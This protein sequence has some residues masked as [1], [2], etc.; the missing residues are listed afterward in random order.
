[1]RSIVLYLA[2]T[3]LEL[4]LV[5]NL[6]AQTISI[7]MIDIYSIN[8]DN[9]IIMLSY[10]FGSPVDGYDAAATS[11]T[12]LSQGYILSTGFI[13]NSTVLPNASTDLN[14]SID[15]DLILNALDTSTNLFD[16]QS[17]GFGLMPAGDSLELSFVFASEEFLNISPQNDMMGIFISGPNPNGGNYMHENISFIPGTNLPIT[18]YNLINPPYNSLIE[19]TGD[20]TLPYDEPFAYNGYTQKIKVKIAVVPLSMY[21]IWI[22]LADGGDAFDDSAIFLEYNGLTSPTSNGTGAN[23]SALAIY[24]EMQCLNDIIPV[25]IFSYAA[26]YNSNGI[27]QVTWSNSSHQIDTMLPAGIYTITASDINLFSDSTVYT[28]EISNGSAPLVSLFANYD[29]LVCHGDSSWIDFTIL[30]GTSPFVVPDDGFFT[31]GDYYFTVID[32]NQCQDILN[33][34]LNE[35]PPLELITTYSDINCF[36]DS[37]WV[38]FDV[39]GGLSPYIIP[40]DGYYTAGNYSFII[41]DSNF[42]SQNIELEIIEPSILNFVA[43]Y[44]DIPCIGDSILVNFSINGGNPPYIMPDN[45]YYTEGSYILYATDQNQCSDSILLVLEDPSPIV[46][47][48]LTINA[49]SSNSMDGSIDITVSGGNPPYEFQWSNGSLYEDLSSIP[50]G[51]YSVTVYDSNI[52]IDSVTV[53]LDYN[54]SI[55]EESDRKFSVLP[56]PA[57]DFIDINGL[58]NNSIMNILS[59]DGKLINH[60]QVDTRNS[61]IDISNYSEGI[62]LIKILSEHSLYSMKLLIQR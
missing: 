13:N 19:P 61:R 45:N 58:E 31:A 43:E 51:N 35:P 2:I 39:I 44:T 47:D 52:C 56:N 4:N 15:F 46:I 1:M 53:Y 8:Q 7:N 33:V 34:V 20:F 40:Q 41:Q 18:V 48:Y 49:S 37:T 25:S 28:F 57:N 26:G 60:Y 23:V 10:S 30:G 59:L 29:T 6:S 38:D 62:Y 16:V 32:S 9:S 50:Y 3:I 42:C 27:S 17:F 36:G 54:V 21:Q 24:S 14:N 12:S 22:R 55:D 11:L 5:Y